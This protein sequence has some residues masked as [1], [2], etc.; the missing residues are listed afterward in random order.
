[1]VSPALLTLRYAG[2]VERHLG[3]EAA[4]AGVDDRAPGLPNELHE[5]DV[6]AGVG[7]VHG[8]LE[9]GELLGVGGLPV[10]VAGR[11]LPIAVGPLSSRDGIDVE[12]VILGELDRDGPGLPF[13][14]RAAVCVGAEL[15]IKRGVGLVENRRR[16]DVVVDVVQPAKDVDILDST[17]RDVALIGPDE[18]W[19]HAP[20]FEVVGRREGRADP[21]VSL[22]RVGLVV[23]RRLDG[24][25][26]LAELTA[27][28]GHHLFLPCLAASCA[29][30]KI[31]LDRTTAL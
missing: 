30:C 23:R 11:D 1:M 8:C 4:G 3:E 19:V 15:G 22:G 26:G 5:A 24:L 13:H 10:A 27:E 21:L 25:K 29:D 28:D 31:R 16:G 7:V 20:R 17:D 12:V 18:H 6:V 14:A 9:G 2:G